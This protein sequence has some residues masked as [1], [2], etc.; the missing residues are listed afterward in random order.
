[1]SYQVIDLIFLLDEQEIRKSV[2]LNQLF[3]FLTLL[4]HLHPHLRAYG[5]KFVILDNFWKLLDQ[6]VQSITKL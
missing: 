4:I 6:I 2:C 5:H 1:M 3:Q